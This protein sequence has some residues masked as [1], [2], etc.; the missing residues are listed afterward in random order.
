MKSFKDA[1]NDDWT[2]KVGNRELRK[3][4]SDTGVNLANLAMAHVNSSHLSDTIFVS[5]CIFCC[6][7]KSAQHRKVTLETWDDLLEVPHFVEIVEGFGVE[8][9]NFFRRL[10]QNSLAEVMEVTMTEIIKNMRE[11]PESAKREIA[12]YKNSMELMNKD[13]QTTGKGSPDTSSE[14]PEL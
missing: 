10:G 3:I 12:E 13:S 9:T 8:L 4:A 14:S 7:Y 5:R 1:K 11:L 6:C 2:Y